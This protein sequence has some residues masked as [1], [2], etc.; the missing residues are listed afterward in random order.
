[1]GHR[2]KDIKKSFRTA[3]QA[4]G[5]EDFT[6]HD[7]RHTAAAWYVQKGIPIR[8]GLYPP[9]CRGGP[10]AQPAA[11]LRAYTIRPGVSSPSHLKGVSFVVPCISNT[12]RIGNSLR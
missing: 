3:C 12:G 7:L 5:I 10:L 4:A 11:I 2:I 6:I 8:T 1:M 9:A